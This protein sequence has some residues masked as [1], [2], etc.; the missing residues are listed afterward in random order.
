MIHGVVALA[1]AALV[2]LTLPGT[3]ELALLTSA[4]LWPAHKG[5]PG[6][7]IERRTL[8]RL[9][10]VIPAH[11]EAASIG[12]C[13]R[14]VAACA[15]P[16]TTSAQIVV[17]A[18]N[19]GDDTAN[20]ARAA[21]ARVIERVDPA[22]RGKGFALEYAFARLLDEGCDAVLVIDAD[23][24]LEG[25]ALTAVADVL[26]KGADGVQMRYLALNPEAAI[27]ARLMNVA[28]MGFNVLRP[29]GRERLGLSVGIFGNG[30]ALSRATLLTTP[31]DA[32]SV[33]EDLEYHL[34]LVRAGGRVHFIENATVRG[35]MPTGGMGAR[36]QRARWEGGRLSLLVNYAPA[37]A[38]EVVHGNWLLL[39]PLLDLLLLPLAFYVTFLLAVLAL[40]GSPARLYAL[41]ALA[42]VMLHVCAGIVVGGGGRREFAAL[43]AAPFYVAWKLAV[44]PAIVRAAGRITPWIRT[45]RE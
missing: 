44:T 21:G 43:A 18:D 26:R 10:V 5:R 42:L 25:D 15:A 22:R 3:V 2:L 11:D 31:Y 6:A 1:A 23:S 14:S 30:F 35:L 37:L 41:G 27:R 8:D 38:R 28:L 39:E 34:R 20:L 13:V 45:A 24:V 40:P 12:H 36:T 29:R 7:P 17:I 4:A 19:C 33:V 9:A 16:P 32:H